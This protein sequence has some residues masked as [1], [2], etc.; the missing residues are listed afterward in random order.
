MYR[1]NE[2]MNRESFGVEEVL[3][4]EEKGKFFSVD[5]LLDLTETIATMAMG[6]GFLLLIAAWLAALR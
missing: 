4:P 1:T 6:A 3:C 5:T 2:T